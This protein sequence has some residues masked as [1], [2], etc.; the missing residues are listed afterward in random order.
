M[1]DNTMHIMAIDLQVL[2]GNAF[3]SI[4]IFNVYAPASTHGI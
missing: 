3:E 2:A 1:M 4:T